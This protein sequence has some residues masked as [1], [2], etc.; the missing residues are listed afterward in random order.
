MGAEHAHIPIGGTVAVF[1]QGP[2]G[3]MATVGARLLGAGLVVAVESVPERIKLA[4]DYGADVVVDFTQEDP[5]Q[6]ILELTDGQGVDA[7]IESL[8]ADT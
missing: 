3:L 5:V 6:K 2:V 7:A 8:G 1:A 4:Q